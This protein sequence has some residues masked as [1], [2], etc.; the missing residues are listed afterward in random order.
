MRICGVIS[1]MT[2]GGSERVM[3]T[4][5][6]TWSEGGHAVTIVTL[7]TTERDAYTLPPTIG[8]VGLGLMAESRHPEER[9]RRGIQRLCALR[10]AICSSRPGSRA[11]SGGV[12]SARASAWIR[13]LGFQ[14]TTRACF[15]AA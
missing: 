8:R 13:L 15:V 12:T 14:P 10:A 1:Q 6:G 2:A 5:A 7:D 3:A 11:R 4:L 9:I